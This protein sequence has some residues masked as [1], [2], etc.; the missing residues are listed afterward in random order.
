MNALILNL[1]ESGKDTYDIAREL[2]VHESVVYNALARLT[3]ETEAAT[4]KRR[5]A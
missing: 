4:R 3:G 5:V 2:G 1:W